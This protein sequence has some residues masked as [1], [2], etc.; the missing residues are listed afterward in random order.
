MATKKEKYISPEVT[1]ISNQDIFAADCSIGASASGIC[2]YGGA[3]EGG[4]D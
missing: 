1:V 4:G 2:V 3:A